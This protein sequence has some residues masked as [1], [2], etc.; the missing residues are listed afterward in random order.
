ML[1]SSGVRVK[2]IFSVWWVSGYAHVFILLS[3][4]IVTEGLGFAVYLSTVNGER[5]HPPSVEDVN[6]KKNP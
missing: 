6:L 4:V 2:V 1:F 5:E 3:V